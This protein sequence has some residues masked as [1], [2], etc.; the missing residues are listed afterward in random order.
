MIVLCAHIFHQLKYFTR[1]VVNNA[2]E[3]SAN[4]HQIDE[5]VIIIVHNSKHYLQLLLLLIVTQFHLL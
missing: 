2:D 4:V 1:S 3:D 5:R